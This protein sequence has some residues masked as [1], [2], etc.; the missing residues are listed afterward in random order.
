MYSFYAH[1]SKTEVEVG[2]NVKEG[3]QIA[4]SGVTGN[5]KNKKGKDQHLHFE[6]RTKKESRKGLDGKRNPNEIVDTKFES[7][8]PTK[9]PQSS[10]GIIKIRKD[11]TKE[12]LNVIWK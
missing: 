4:L 6:L 8:D 3:S 12:I 1:L 10:V 9:V 11:K 7:Q 2:D 5:A